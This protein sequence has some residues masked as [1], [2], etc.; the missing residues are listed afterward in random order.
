[1][2][3]LLLAAFAAACLSPSGAQAQGRQDFT[4]INRT[5]YQIDQI[6]VGPSSSPNWGRDLL[7]QNVLVNGRS[8]NVTFPGRS[9]EC[10]WDIKL[11]YNDGDQS[12]LRQANLCRISRITLFWDRQRNDTRFVAE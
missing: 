2:R 6:Y 12:E 11:V 4:M 1:M 9:S 5:G 10:L 3:R 7:G 8:F